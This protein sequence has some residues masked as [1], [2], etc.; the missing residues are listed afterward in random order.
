MFCPTTFAD[1][2]P[3]ILDARPEL[4]CVTLET[5][6]QKILKWRHSENYAAQWVNALKGNTDLVSMCFCRFIIRD[7]QSQLRYSSY[8]YGK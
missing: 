7:L 5:H 2:S 1:Y 8:S 3:N 4:K 6:T